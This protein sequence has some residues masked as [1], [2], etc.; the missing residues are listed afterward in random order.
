M[1][2]INFPPGSPQDLQSRRLQGAVLAFDDWVLTYGSV[3]IPLTAQ[4]RY[5]CTPSACRFGF[6]SC[7]A[8]AVVYWATADGGQWHWHV[9]DGRP[10]DVRPGDSI[11]HLNRSPYADP[12]V[13]MRAAE[14]G[15][16]AY[17]AGDVR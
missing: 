3:N 11:V 9:I 1:S 13:A 2:A 16:T 10:L 4:R 17:L 5:R 7:V 6:H 15:V 12:D 8:A 14:L